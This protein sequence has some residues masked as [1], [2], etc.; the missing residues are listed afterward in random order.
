MALQK[1][2]FLAYYATQAAQASVGEW[3]LVLWHGL[4]LDMTVAGYITALPILFLLINLWVS[5]PDKVGRWVLNGYFTVVSIASAALVAVDLGLYE[6][7]GFRLDSTILI[8]LADPKEA[9]ASVDA[10][11]AIRQSIIFVLYAALLIVCYRRVVRL[12][13]GRAL[14]WYRALPWSVVMLLV[15]GLDFLAIRGGVGTSVANVSKVCFSPTLFLNHAATNPIFSFL[16]TLGKQADFAA[17]YPFYDAETLAEQF[18]AL[19]G[20]QP[21]EGPSEQVLKS[22]RPNVLLVVLESF[23]STVFEADEE[24]APIMPELRKLRDEAIFFENFY[25]SSF[26]TDRG[27]M[28]ILSGFPG[29]TRASL[30]KL[31]P[32]CLALPSIAR[33]LGREGYRTT[34]YYG[35]DLNFT[36]QASYMYATGWQQLV[37]QKDMSFDAPTS[38]WGYDD[39]VVGDFVTDEVLRLSAEGEPFLAGWLTLSSHEP[40]EVPYEQF[41]DPR[42]NAFAFTDHCIGRMIERLKASPAWEN[43]LVVLIPDHG[44]RPFRQGQYTDTET[45]QIPMWWLGGAIKE[46]RTV[47][48]F[49]AQIDLAATLLAQLGIAHDD[50]DYSKDLFD[51]AIPK[52]AY[53][54]Y[55]EGFGILEES[56]M[57][58]WDGGS[59]RTNEG[60][61]ER[62][63]QMGRT[64]LQQTYL[65]ISKR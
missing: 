30:M 14:R 18:D 52:F 55:N 13:E 64:L 27:Q 25:A 3:W 56:G 17:E 6:Y 36:N 33:S 65:D 43:L 12:Y 48:Q 45:F 26:R 21:S 19:R 41:S 23:G 59:N 5:I 46:P 32:K 35:G 16:S 53:Y 51:P 62:Q 1:P 60:A 11:M 57:S 42:T 54:T 37:W 39:A 7:W 10:W 9:M 49:G 8:Y 63:L 44:C 20:N 50:F 29:Q 22:T 58:L 38:K 34:Y 24:G 15:A 31:T 61:D 2:L 47:A 40:F 28:A 4:K